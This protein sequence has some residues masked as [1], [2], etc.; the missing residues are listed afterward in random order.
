MPTP[1]VPPV[2]R[3]AAKWARRAASASTE[4]Q[5]GIQ[6]TTADWAGAASAAEGAYKAG[7]A[8]AATAGRYGKGVNR[9]GTQRWKKG[10][11]DKGPSRYAQGVGV[12]EGDYSGQVAPFLEA[13]GRT[14]L[15][16]RGPAGS[17][18]NYQRSAAIG[19]ALRQL[20]ERR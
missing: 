16:P 19:K 15:P 20:R 2:A 9:A 8:A 7:V 1:T 17:E 5:E 13:I 3:V 14:D 4:Y 18:G 12:A 10:A 6:S 11:L